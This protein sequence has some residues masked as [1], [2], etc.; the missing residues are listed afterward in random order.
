MNRI[1]AAAVL[2]T[3]GLLPGLAKERDWKDGN[4][5]E[6]KHLRKTVD[7]DP[8]GLDRTKKKKKTRVVHYSVVRVEAGGKIYQGVGDSKFE[9]DEG[10]I[11]FDVD[12]DRLY[13]R[14]PDGRVHSL[15]LS[16]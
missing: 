8:T 1:V 5:L 9:H 13:L 11:R 7:T 15:R 6:V 10:P 16:K 2:L 12:A 4:V 14:E 3:F